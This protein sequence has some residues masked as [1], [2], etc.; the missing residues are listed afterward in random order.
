MFHTVRIPLSTSHVYVRTS[1]VVY[2]ENKGEESRDLEE[3]PR[4]R[5]RRPALRKR[6]SSRRLS[7]ALALGPLLLLISTE[8]QQGPNGQCLRP[9]GSSNVRKLEAHH[10]GR[11][12][13]ASKSGALQSGLHTPVSAAQGKLISE[14]MIHGPHRV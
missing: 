4:E 9:L 11:S 1:G 12:W 2:R 7:V 3:G 8:S 10:Q 6:F 14:A 5:V 13:C